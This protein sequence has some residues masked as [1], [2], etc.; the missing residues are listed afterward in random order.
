MY[1]YSLSIKK[2]KK[3]PMILPTFETAVVLG[4]VSFCKANVAS[5][6]CLLGRF[7][8]DPE[9]HTSLFTSFKATKVIG[10]YCLPLFHSPFPLSSILFSNL[11]T[12]N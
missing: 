9:N 1:K 5:Y 7:N 12:G 2:K 4:L 10:L 11:A 6:P 8:P 3:F